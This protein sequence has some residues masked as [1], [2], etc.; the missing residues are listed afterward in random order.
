M[1]QCQPLPLWL[2]EDLASR[3]TVVQVLVGGRGLGERKGAINMGRNL[4]FS[5]PGKYLLSPASEQVRLVPEVPHV[6][7]K[8]A[9][10]F[11]NQA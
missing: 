10:V 6:H 7:P 11:V 9:P 1:E 8:D 5:I 3:L 2:Q 4:A